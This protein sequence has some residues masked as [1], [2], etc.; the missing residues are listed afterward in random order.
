MHGDVLRL[1]QRSQG[2]G[3]LTARQRKMAAGDRRMNPHMWDG[4]REPAAEH[5]VVPLPG[6]PV[7]ACCV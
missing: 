5:G 2:T 3:R 4:H 7:S 6:L 1:A